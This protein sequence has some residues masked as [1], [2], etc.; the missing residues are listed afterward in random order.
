MAPSVSAVGAHTI[1]LELSRAWHCEVPR[2][3]NLP[4]L[5][6]FCWR[7]SSRR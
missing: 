1:R 6:V 7:C 4:Y 2:E 3:P 5:E